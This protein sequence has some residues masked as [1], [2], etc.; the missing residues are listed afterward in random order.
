MA[1][2][3]VQRK[4]ALG[5]YRLDVSKDGLVSQED[6]ASLGQQV[7]EQLHVAQGSPHS[8]RIVHA[9]ISLW[10]AY[11]KPADKDGDNAISLD[12]FAEAHTAFLQTPDARARGVDVNAEV[13]AALD[14]NGDGKLDAHE[15]AALLK[16]MGISTEE[17]HTA[18]KHLDR[19]GDGSISCEEMASDWWEYWNSEDRAAPGNWFYG[20]Y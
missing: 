12:D 17:A 10:H 7:V 14:R 11:G 4:M 13:F 18:F 3:F 2:P 6:L 5:F 9:F 1:S 16:P 15:Y 19:N 20:S 8:D